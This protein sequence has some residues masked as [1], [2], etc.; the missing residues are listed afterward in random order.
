M[1]TRVNIKL[2]TP[3]Q[4]YLNQSAFNTKSTELYKNEIREIV[5]TEIASTGEWQKNITSFEKIKNQIENNGPVQ[6]KNKKK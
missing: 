1:G 3:K 5:E 4:T 2:N 6:Y